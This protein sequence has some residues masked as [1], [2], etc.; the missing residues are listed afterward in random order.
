MK[1]TF[2]TA[3]IV[4]ISMF[5]TSCDSDEVEPCPV[6]KEPVTL[7]INHL[8]NGVALKYN[9]LYK[10]GQNNDM[11]FTKNKFYLSNIVAVKADGEKE[12]ISEI[13]L[14]DYSLDSNAREITGSIE[15]G[16][17]VAIEF[18]LGVTEDLNSKDPATYPID[19]PLSVANNMY[20][21]WSSQYV[22]SKIEGFEISGS[23]TV[24][25]VIHTGTQSLY[26][27]EINVPNTFTMTTGGNSVSINLDMYTLLNQ[28]GYT[29]DLVAN[30]ESHTADNLQLAVHYMD[31]FMYAFN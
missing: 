16:D 2:Y 28:S 5:T 31:N 30:G 25:F 22:F 3:I 8:Y 19:H 15:K 6:V 23:D 14:M 11:W 12:L 27:P 20:W 17:Y 13:Y 4:F 29:F 9:T 10:S 24:S 26:R 1:I 18:D 21:G 7:N